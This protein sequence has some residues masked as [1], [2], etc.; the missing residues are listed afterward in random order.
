M[1]VFPQ[2]L[3]CWFQGPNLFSNYKMSTMEMSYWCFS[4]ARSLCFVC[5]PSFRPHQDTRQTCCPRKQDSSYFFY[6]TVRIHFILNRF[7]HSVFIRS[8]FTFESSVKPFS[9]I[10]HL[11]CKNI[12][13]K[14]SLKILH[15]THE[16]KEYIRFMMNWVWYLRCRHDVRLLKKYLQVNKPA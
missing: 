13:T 2:Y 14:D 1:A 7:L 12:Y 9:H 4:P 3:I 11:I 10:K 5:L 8:C 6:K 15:I 16:R